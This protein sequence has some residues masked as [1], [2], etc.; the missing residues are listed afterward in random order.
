MLTISSPKVSD[1]EIHQRAES[2]RAGA[3]RVSP[4]AARQ[5]YRRDRLTAVLVYP[6]T[7]GRSYVIWLGQSLLQRLA[8][9]GLIEDGQIVEPPSTGCLD[10]QLV[11][12]QDRRAS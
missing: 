4:R 9:K 12:R 5:R 6:N 2:I 3:G 7:V 11:R 1:F 8:E 10:F